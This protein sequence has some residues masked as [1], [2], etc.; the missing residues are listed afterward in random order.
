MGS[1][2]FFRKPLVFQSK[3]PGIR[4]KPV[5]HGLEPGKTRFLKK[6]NGFFYEPLA[7]GRGNGRVRRQGRGRLD[8]SAAH[9]DVQS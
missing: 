2:V 9:D 4:P 8:S 6:E 3:E 1:F 7:A 5:V